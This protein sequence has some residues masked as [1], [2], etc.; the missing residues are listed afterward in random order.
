[1]WANAVQEFVRLRQR[2]PELAAHPS[3]RALE[4]HVI[5]YGDSWPKA[6]NLFKQ[7]SLSPM[8]DEGTKSW[9]ITETKL[10]TENS[11]ESLSLVACQPVASRPRLDGD[12]N[13]EVWQQ[14]FSSRT[15]CT[16][17]LAPDAPLDKSDQVILAYDQEFLF[18]AIRCQKIEG[19]LYPEPNRGRT[20]NPSL[21]MFDRVELAF[22][23][24]RDQAWPLRLTVD[25]RGWAA[26][27]C[28]NSPAW[29]PEWFVAAKHSPTHWMIEAAVPWSALGGHPE[30][31]TYWGL[32]M[33]RRLPRK[34]DNIWQLPA[35]PSRSTL[36]AI[37]SFANERFQ[38]L[39]FK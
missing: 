17:G 18:I 2:D 8:A 37:P 10:Q 11:G 16:T 5:R 24:D 34:S 32:G 23:V 12:F 9:A 27:H 38:P 13:D 1:M 19:V 35:P 3:M 29:D 31:G 20:R 25:A 6:A 28:G 4:S 30:P 33:A 39:Q 22:D 7:L 36:L 14:V 15:H 26:D 21:E